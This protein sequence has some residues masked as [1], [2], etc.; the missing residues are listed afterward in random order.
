VWFHPRRSRLKSPPI[1]R[2]RAR[3]TGNDASTHSL[4]IVA[5]LLLFV[6]APSL[7]AFY[8]DWLWF[9]EVGYQSVYL[10]ILRTQALLFTIVFA[11]AAIWI[12]VNLRIALR[13]V[14][15]NAR[16]SSRDRASRSPSVPRSC[17]SWRMPCRSSP[18]R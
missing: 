15:D 2:P 3:C 12:D 4:A 5:F 8:T 17:G 18:R 13:S 16:C 14:R 9:G 10:T 6:A 7:I 1:S 11:V